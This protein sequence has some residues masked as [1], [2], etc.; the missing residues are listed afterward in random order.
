MKL[1]PLDKCWW[2]SHPKPGYRK[3]YYGEPACWRGWLDLIFALIWLRSRK[4]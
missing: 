4:V 1:C 3:C 2:Y